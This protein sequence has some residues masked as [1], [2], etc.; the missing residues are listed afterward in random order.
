M[1]EYFAWVIDHRDPHKV[2]EFT[3]LSTGGLQQYCDWADL[4]SKGQYAATGQMV[5]DDVKANQMIKDA[6]YE[7]TSEWTQALS[8]FYAEI[9]PVSEW[10]PGSVGE[11]A[12]R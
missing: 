11:N 3:I 7:R 9:K 2:D 1:I 4:I 10:H 6:G 12:N 8:G 5:L